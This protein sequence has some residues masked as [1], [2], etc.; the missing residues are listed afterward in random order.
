MI[1]SL[2]STGLLVAAFAFA[3]DRG[4][5]RGSV[6]G[7]VLIALCGLGMV[8]L[9]LLRNDC[10]S[11]TDACER[12]VE[13][14]EVSWQHTAH[15]VV[16][17]PVFA[18]AVAAPVLLALRFRAD[19]GWRSLAPFSAGAA[20]VVAALFAL[21]GLE[22]AASWNGVIQRVA[23]SAAL[24]WLEVV[25]LRLL[26]VMTAAP[27]PKIRNNPPVSSGVVG[28]FHFT[29]EGYLESMHDEVP[30]YDELQEETA[31]ASD[32]ASARRI[33]E[34]GVGTGE[35]SRRVLAR[36][37]GATLVGIDASP[38]MLAEASL[39]GADLRVARL[40]DPLPDGPFDLVVSCLA[41]HH[42]DAAGKRDLFD[43]IAAALPEGGRFVLADVIVPEDP[44]DA[45]TPCT[46][47]FDLPDRLDDQLRWLD[48]AGFE[49]EATWVRGDLAVVR[50]TRRSR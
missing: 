16:S 38:E 32:G 37:P 5:R 6:A 17:V 4:V 15:D 26:R 8:A 36:H 22:P 28:Q 44:A 31:R 29:P 3:L 12:R 23:V 34:L 27:V 24:V 39:P 11:L 46:P 40:E 48:E 10:S 25:A 45:V 33:L 42:L 19:P 14:G 1:V 7:P 21:G 49:A 2:V 30:R 47:G 43:R 50:A 35:T 18:A 41:I 9:G 13:A 20:V